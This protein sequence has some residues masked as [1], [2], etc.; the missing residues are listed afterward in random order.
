MDRDN[1]RD[2]EE[3]RER[4]RLA[5]AEVEAADRAQQAENAGDAERISLER[6]PLNVPSVRF[7]PFGAPIVPRDNAST[8]TLLN[9]SWLTI[10]HPQPIM[11]TPS[12]DEPETVEPNNRGAEKK[13]PATATTD[14]T[15]VASPARKRAARKSNKS[16]E[17]HTSPARTVANQRNAQKSTGPKTEAGKR[18]SSRNAIKHGLCNKYWPLPGENVMWREDL[19]T[20]MNSELNPKGNA[21]LGLMIRNVTISQVKIE[22][23]FSLDNSRAAHRAREARKELRERWAKSVID[24][25]RKWEQEAD[26]AV[27]EL[28]QTVPGCEELFNNYH[29]LCTQLNID[30][31]GEVAWTTGNHESLVR[32]SG[33]TLTILGKMP[34]P[35]RVHSD[36]IIVAR[37][38]AAKLRRA[39]DSSKLLIHDR[40]NTEAERLCDQMRLPA[41]KARADRA[42]RELI[43]MIG[44]HMD[45]L[46]R[47]IAELRP[48]AESELDDAPWNCRL[49]ASDDGR[50]YHRYAT[51]ER[52]AFDRAVKLISDLIKAG[53]AGDKAAQDDA[54]DEDED[55]HVEEL[56]NSADE[57]NQAVTTLCGNAEPLIR[58]TQEIS[59]NEANERAPR[60]PSISEQPTSETAFEGVQRPP[61]DSQS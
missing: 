29:L 40:Y 15:E 52:R 46:Q 31:H 3:G 47:R 36:A 33:R 28:L 41:L 1:E 49:D 48:D 6:D 2:A 11:P 22:R 19:E 21:L 60:S 16:E 30:E 4:G 27:L 57:P 24:A 20:R 13:S 35:Y 54:S 7:G 34:S 43:S 61:D 5:A 39:D 45:D 55:V 8:T 50:L 17:K 37:D 25:N 38:V 53:H 23:A 56:G 32:L 58:G 26:V 51:D 59:R 12:E 44:A 9:T 18:A 10:D 14:E 42:R